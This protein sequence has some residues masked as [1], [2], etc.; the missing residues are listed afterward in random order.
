MWRTRV[1]S[2]VPGAGDDPVVA[3]TRLLLDVLYART[4]GF[5]TRSATACRTLRETDLESESDTALLHAIVRL[6]EAEILLETDEDEGTLRSLL[7]ARLRASR[8]A[9]PWIVAECDS[10]SP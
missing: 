4:F 7:D 8:A 2:Q 6:R 1:D 9:A 3:V 10:L 5:D